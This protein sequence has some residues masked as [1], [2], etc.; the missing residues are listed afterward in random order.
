VT[1]SYETHHLEWRSIA[2]E[3]RY[4][5]NW[6][7]AFA[8]IHGE[9]IAHLEIRTLTPPH[10]PLPVTETGYRSHFTSPSEIDAY[11]NP[12][13]FVLAW[14]DHEASAERWKVQEADR[15]GIPVYDHVPALKETAQKIFENLKDNLSL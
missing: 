4:C 8:Q 13:A 3:L 1:A 6:N 12:V 2:I 7:D 15:F 11:G 9:P 14:L 5:P 10:R